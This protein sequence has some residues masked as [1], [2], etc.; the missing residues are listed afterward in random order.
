MECTSKLWRLSSATRTIT[1]N[2]GKRMFGSTCTNAAD[3][4]DVDWG[5]WS[6]WSTCLV[7]G[8]GSSRSGDAAPWGNRTISR[9][10]ALTPGLTSGHSRPPT[11]QTAGDAALVLPQPSTLCLPAAPALA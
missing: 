8:G 1:A 3:R 4:V 2:A 5:V 10:L 9:I 11:P 7:S 6:T